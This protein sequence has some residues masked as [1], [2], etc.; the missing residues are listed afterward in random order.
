ELE[1]AELDARVAQR[2]A[3]LRVAES[4]L[5]AGRRYDAFEELEL[6]RVAVLGAT[7]ARVLFGEADPIGQE[8]RI[9]RVPF[10][11]V[12]VARGRGMDAGG[13]DQDNVVFIPLATALRRVL[14]VPYI[15]AVFVQARSSRELDA[16]EAEVLEVLG[17]RHRV[18]A[19]VASAFVVQNQAEL[20]RT[21]REATRALARL[22][23]AAAALA[24]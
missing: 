4:R 3:E 12:G 1:T 21:E 20:L 23:V 13:A 17:R 18:R 10:E 16:L 11:V 22:V 5:A 19:G 14:N 15:D 8:V 24:L 7:V 9:G 2:R 6:R